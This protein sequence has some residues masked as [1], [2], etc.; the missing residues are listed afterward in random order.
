MITATAANPPDHL[1]ARDTE[2]ALASTGGDAALAQELLA[3]LLH[4]LPDALAALQAHAATADWS[5]VSEEA[6]RLRGATRYCGVPALDQALEC[7]ERAAEE[8]IDARLIRASLASVET[9]A[10]RLAAMDDG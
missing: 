7:L 3:T 2:A 10:D 8:G 4:Q 9:Q 6:H 1:P 5:G